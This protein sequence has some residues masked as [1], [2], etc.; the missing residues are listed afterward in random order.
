MLLFVMIG[1]VD[2]LHTHIETKNK[3]IKIETES[4]TIADSYLVP[5]F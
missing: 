1:R 3:E 2:G 5:E 4:K